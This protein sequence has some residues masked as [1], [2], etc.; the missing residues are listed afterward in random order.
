MSLSF[1]R[2]GPWVAVLCF[3]A[4]A[5]VA[6]APAQ[7]IPRPRRSLEIT[8]TNSA[9][10]LTNLSRL[11]T[12]K[13][14]INEL[15][16]RLRALKKSSPDAGFDAWS[17]PYVAPPGGTLPNKAALRELLQ[18]QMNWGLSP[19]ELGNTRD[20]AD[21]DNFSFFEN[22]KGENNDRKSSLQQ[23]YD[24]LNSRN[25]DRK[26]RDG[27]NDINGFGSKNQ[28]GRKD[29]DP[30]DDSSL[31]EGIRDKAE[32]L[33]SVVKDD[34][35]SIFNPSRARSSFDNFFGLREEAPDP[36]P[37]RQ[38]KSG[39]GSESFIDQFKKTLDK[40]SAASGVAPGLSKLLPAAMTPSSSLVPGLEPFAAS[41]HHELTQSSPGNAMSL[42]DPT[43]LRDMNSTL[44][45]QWNPLYKPPKLELP[46]PAPP[47]ASFMQVPRRQF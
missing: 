12:K 15:D 18:R 47:S 3:T 27:P 5:L 10:I 1:L 14:G 25:S 40:Q 8:E 20:N 23:F 39:L 6:H 13:E 34:S 7:G 37:V 26:K 30:E 9:E 17:I 2:H 41:T 32:K 38:S 44:L 36:E 46:K 29:F 11:T 24:A 35:S 43:T 22:N 45:N 31:P 16:E 42:E 4:A 28:Y 21:S 33:K 19:E